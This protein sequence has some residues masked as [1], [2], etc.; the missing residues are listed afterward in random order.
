MIN[1]A[2]T[3]P[4]P[5]EAICINIVKKLA[6]EV[7]QGLSSCGNARHIERSLKEFE[8]CDGWCESA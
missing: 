7:Y 4:R 1:A 3:K 6:G 5:S 8:D 2:A